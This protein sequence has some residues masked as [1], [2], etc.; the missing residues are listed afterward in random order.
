MADTTFPVGRI[1]AYVCTGGD[2][3]DAEVVCKRAAEVTEKLISNG[4]SGFLSV[5]LDEKNIV[6]ASKDK[7]D[8][9][10]SGDRRKPVETTLKENK[11]YDYSGNVFDEKQY[12]G[13]VITL[14]TDGRY[15]YTESPISSYI[16]LGT[17]EISDDGILTMTEDAEMGYPGMKNRFLFEG[18]RLIFIQ[19]GSTNFGMVK[20][21]DGEVFYETEYQTKLLSDP[22]VYEGLVP[23][24]GV[25]LK[26]LN[27]TAEGCR[28][29][30]SYDPVQTNGEMGIMTGESWLL[31]KID[32]DGNRVILCTNPE[33]SASDQKHD[34]AV[35]EDTLELDLDWAKEYGALQPGKYNISFFIT[36]DKP[37]GGDNGYCEFDLSYSFVIE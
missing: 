11:T 4:D 23:Q 28:A 33:D 15:S 34:I 27:V 30:F 1:Y 2:E 6:S 26:L 16:G 8:S 31:S 9:G 14:F 5:K 10:P 19:E 37:I 35:G 21:K 3:K 36:T 25:S 18:D 17:Y 13:F 7:G 22:A 12:I 32:E 24:V 29:V 20:V